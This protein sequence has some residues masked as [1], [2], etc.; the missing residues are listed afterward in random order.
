MVFI[1]WL[2]MADAFGR[3][4]A[5]LRGVGYETATITGAKF[6]NR[7]KGMQRSCGSKTYNKK[8]RKSIFRADLNSDFNLDFL[9]NC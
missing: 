6:L 1:K 7:P 2:C 9:A 8:T 4:V 5:R 3:A